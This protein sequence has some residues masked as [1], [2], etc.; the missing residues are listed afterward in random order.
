[1]AGIFALHRPFARRVAPANVSVGC[2]RLEILHI[3]APLPSGERNA[4]C[5]HVAVFV[6]VREESVAQRGG[7]VLCPQFNRA[8]YPVGRVGVFDGIPKREHLAAG[9]EEIAAFDVQRVDAVA[10]VYRFDERRHLFLLVV[11]RLVHAFHGNAAHQ[12]SH[13]ANGEPLKVECDAR[14]GLHTV[15]RPDVGI[16]HFVGHG[17]KVRVVGIDQPERTAPWRNVELLFTQ[18]GDFFVFCHRRF[19]DFANIHSFCV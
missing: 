19:E 17:M 5:R 8:F 3:L 7:E 18:S 1:M 11:R 4:H 12:F 16:K 10:L 15:F 6:E 9:E 13:T 14:N 2:E